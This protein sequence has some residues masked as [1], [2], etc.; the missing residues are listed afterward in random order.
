MFSIIIVRVENVAGGGLLHANFEHERFRPVLSV[1]GKTLKPL[2]DLE[3]GVCGDSG[4]STPSEEYKTPTFEVVS[5]PGSSCLF[6]FPEKSSSASIQGCFTP[7][8]FNASI[9]NISSSATVLPVQPQRSVKACNVQSNEQSGPISV[10]QTCA[11]EKIMPSSVMQLPAH[12]SDRCSVSAELFVPQASIVT[13]VSN[14]FSGITVLTSSAAPLDRISSGSRQAGK[15]TTFA[16]LPNQTTWMRERVLRSASDHDVVDS[17]I[18]SEIISSSQLVDIRMRLEE[19]RRQIE[20]EK[21]RMAVQWTRNRQQAGNDAFVQ[22]INKSRPLAERAAAEGLFPIELSDSG[23]EL[24]KQAVETVAEQS[25]KQTAKPLSGQNRQRS[26]S[27]VPVTSS[28]GHDATVSSESPRVSRSGVC[29]S[30]FKSTSSVSG[31][32]HSL[33]SGSAIMIGEHGSSVPSSASKER[34]SDYGTSLDRLNSS[35]MEL[36]GE[37]MRLSL[38]QDQIKSLVGPDNDSSL[39]SASSATTN[40]QFYLSPAHES[41]AA[42]K[43]LDPSGGIIGQPVDTRY[44]PLSYMPFQQYGSIPSVVPQQVGLTDVPYHSLPS[45]YVP[46]PIPARFSQL[47][48]L[49]GLFDQFQQ[50]HDDGQP[51][52]QHNLDEVSQSSAVCTAST[53]HALSA[54]SQSTP[55]SSVCSPVLMSV[56]SPTA[57]SSS[58]Q[59]G[60]ANDTVATETS[61]ANF[62]TTFAP[63]T[64]ANEA[65]FMNFDDETTPRRSKP[66]LGSSR[67]VR[68]KAGSEVRVLPS[69]VSDASVLDTTIQ[70]TT[71]YPLEQ[72]PAVSSV[73]P[74]VGFMIVENEAVDETVCALLYFFH[75]N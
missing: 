13:Q 5:L 54:Y 62:Q 44:M 10:G 18:D 58:L 14:S 38:Q 1:G 35:L 30:A 9:S 73:S 3:V 51:I 72:L 6:E 33:P 63:S 59:S 25:S 8:T 26:A 27:F 34:V 15:K 67:N 40:S 48:R 65:F 31:K 49:D 57:L 60:V 16:P 19:R 22:V 43:L 23:V 45:S 7:L 42:S 39:N 64:T 75:L 41:H 29:Q 74:A 2:N 66:V 24:E 71:N 69:V 61:P 12:H 17:I 28:A 36:Q 32:D 52:Q 21:R 11:A 20:N 55:M 37:I 68:S 56:C 46:A 47:S 53:A 4:S 70:R 50:S